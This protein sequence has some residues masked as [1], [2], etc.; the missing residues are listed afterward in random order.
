M[1]IDFHTHAFPD[2][3]APRAIDGLMRGDGAGTGVYDS[4]LYGRHCGGTK[5]A[6]GRGTRGLE[7]ASADRDEADADRAR[8]SIRE[9]P[10]V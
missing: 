4:R 7:R 1:L 6:D 8:E 2:A 5:Q 9:K 10:R 3:L